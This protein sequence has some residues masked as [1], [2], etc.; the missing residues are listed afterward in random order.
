MAVAAAVRV[1]S[2]HPEITPPSNFNDRRDTSRL[3]QSRDNQATRAR[4]ATIRRPLWMA[5]PVFE[6]RDGMGFQIAP[7]ASQPFRHALR[8]DE[9]DDIGLC[10]LNRAILAE[11]PID[12]K[13]LGVSS[14]THNVSPR[15]RFK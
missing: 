2:R 5:E 7:V 12:A 11:R 1:G 10:P 6:C 8:C 3:A 9:T 14:L 4:N 15:K 13:A